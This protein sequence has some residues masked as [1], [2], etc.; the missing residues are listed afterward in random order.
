MDVGVS[1][2]GRGR[3][4]SYDVL[5]WTGLAVCSIAFTTYY[6]VMEPQGWMEVD[7]VGGDATTN[8]TCKQKEAGCSGA[9]AGYGSKQAKSNPVSASAS[10]PCLVPRTETGKPDLM[11]DGHGTHPP[12]HRRARAVPCYNNLETMGSGWRVWPA[13]QKNKHVVLLFLQT[14]LV[15]QRR[16]RFV[17]VPPF[18][19][20]HA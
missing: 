15:L 16:H 17:R 7:G 5:A 14:N 8:S 10:F 18:V 19:L 12:T 6:S 3:A 20:T 9:L 11:G 4:S 2:T 1:C 13:Q